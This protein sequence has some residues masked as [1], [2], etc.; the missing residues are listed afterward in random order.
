MST[1]GN[2]LS[3]QVWPRLS[4]IRINM[5][6]IAALIV[7]VLIFYVV[8]INKKKIKKEPIV[9]PKAAKTY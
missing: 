6:Y 9:E 3:V 7:V 8:K 1:G 2:S 5:E 4:L